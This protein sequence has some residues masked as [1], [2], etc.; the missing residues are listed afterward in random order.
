MMYVCLR[1]TGE[2]KI[3]MKALQDNENESAYEQSVHKGEINYYRV[4]K[5]N[6]QALFLDV[7]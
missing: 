3:A 6:E 7:R 5:I 1:T 4:L 2:L